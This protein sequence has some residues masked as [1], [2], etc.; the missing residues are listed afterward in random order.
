MVHTLCLEQSRS[1]GLS[2]PVYTCAVVL[3]RTTLHSHL[4]VCCGGLCQ[5]DISLTF[6]VIRTTCSFIYIDYIQSSPTSSQAI[7]KNSKEDEENVKDGE[8]NEENVER[9]PHLL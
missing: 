4:P 5:V 6:F 2:K 7:V 3:Y 8:D 9:I 1:G